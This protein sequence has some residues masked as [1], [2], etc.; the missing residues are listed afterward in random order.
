MLNYKLA[1]QY[2]WIDEAYLDQLVILG[3]ITEQEKQDI[4][5]Q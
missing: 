3:L 5:S 2:G 4:V 1:Y